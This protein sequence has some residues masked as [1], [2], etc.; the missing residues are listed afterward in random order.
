MRKNSIVLGLILVLTGVGLSAC[1]EDEQNRAL[2][3]EKGEY[4]GKV[5]QG[6]SEEEQRQ[7]KARGYRQKY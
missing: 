2:K 1:R 7:L 5:D 3:I 6:L 4:A